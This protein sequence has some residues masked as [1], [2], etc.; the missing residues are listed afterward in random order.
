MNHTQQD[1]EMIKKESQNILKTFEFCL[2]ILVIPWDV[3]LLAQSKNSFRKFIIISN[4]Q[5][6]KFQSVQKVL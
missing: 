3:E 1:V 5:K 4:L 2:V 6:L